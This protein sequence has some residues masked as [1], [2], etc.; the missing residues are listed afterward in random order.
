VDTA[1]STAVV[2]TTFRLA[3]ALVAADVVG[4]S[5]GTELQGK[6]KKKDGL[7][8]E[9]VV[10]VDGILYAGARAPSIEGKAFLVGVKIDDLFAP[11][12]GRLSA[13]PVVISLS[14]GQNTGIRDLA[15]LSDG[16][17]LVLS[18]PTR[19]DPDTRY[20]L[21]LV[22]PAACWPSLDQA[23]RAAQG[24]P[25][26]RRG[27]RTRPGKGRGGPAARFELRQAYGNRA[28]RRPAEW[29]R[30]GISDAA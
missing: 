12:A 21:F 16:R 1:G 27:R 22:A 19:D 28:V 26:R 5:F 2:E 10:V 30:G 17:L 11:G 8:I 4:G 25:D 20:G 7:N 15:P 18:G 14:L 24:Y 13:K 3:D 29:R 23:S 6:D 9:G